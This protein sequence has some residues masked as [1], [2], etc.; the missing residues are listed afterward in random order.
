MTADL[1]ELGVGAAAER[2]PSKSSLRPRSA[3]SFLSDGN[4]PSPPPTDPFRS[5]LQPTCGLRGGR[6]AGR[7]GLARPARAPGQ[8]RPD[9]VHEGGR[10]LTGENHR[11]LIDDSLA[12]CV[13]RAELGAGPGLFPSI[14]LDSRA[15]RRNILNQK[16]PTL[17]QHV[18][19]WVRALGLAPAPSPT[20][21]STTSTG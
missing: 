7:A 5:A 9:A 12:E 2:K 21:G 11:Q 19:K 17:F 10:G 6:G 18:A 16:R 20:P 3:Q 14:R 15:V 4:A 8:E 13:F 1:A